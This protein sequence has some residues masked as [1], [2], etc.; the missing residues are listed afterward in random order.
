MK[1]NAGLVLNTLE[2]ISHWCSTLLFLSVFT[3][4]VDS[5]PG[6]NQPFVWPSAE[7][8]NHL[9]SVLLLGVITVRT[10]PGRTRLDVEALLWPA[11]ADQSRS[12]STAQFFSFIA[13]VFSWREADLWPP[14]SAF[15][16][17]WCLTYLVV[18]LLR[19]VSF[20]SRFCWTVPRSGEAVELKL[21]FFYYFLP[22]SLKK[23]W[24]KSWHTGSSIRFSSSEL[25]R[26]K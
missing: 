22:R 25:C 21:F 19:N 7:E 8:W 13:D 11:V 5:H 26:T 4:L 10:D 12:S 6:P 23:Y 1:A 15:H 2:R 3:Q 16:W 17:R 20:C 18:S 14:G 9:V 24:N